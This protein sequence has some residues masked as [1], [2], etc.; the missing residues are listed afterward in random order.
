MIDIHSHL[1]YG[2]DDGSYCLEES[3]EMISAAA[4]LGI[5][6]IIATPHYQRKLYENTAVIDR[7]TIL[8]AK[9]AE[10]GIELLLGSELY[11]N[12]DLI[13]HVRKMSRKSKLTAQYLLMEIP[14][15]F[16]CE[17]AIKMLNRIKRYQ[18][19]IVIAHPERNLLLMD[20]MKSFIQF[21]E[22]SDILLQ[23]DA[24]SIAGRYGH[25]VKEYAKKLI[26]LGAVEFIASNAHSSDDYSK[27]YSKAVETI[28]K[29]CSPRE[30]N[31]LLK[32]NASFILSN[33]PLTYYKIM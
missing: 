21:I 24:G 14:F 20:K 7:Y 27:V 12:E 28:Y 30:A 17:K 6:K 19:K 10:L 11:A 15:N 2:V 25:K 4:K 5:D 23:T 9:A 13:V 33:K 32:S 3:I 31:L 26:S 1:I 18:A 8:A 29:W 16:T 22:S